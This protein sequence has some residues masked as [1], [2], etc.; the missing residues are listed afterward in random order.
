[1]TYK[2][3]TSMA[4][5]GTSLFLLNN[6]LWILVWLDDNFL[7]LLV[8]YDNYNDVQRIGSYFCKFTGLIA[9]MFIGVYF[10]TLSSVGRICSAKTDIRQ[11]SFIALF[12]V[13]IL[14][15]CAIIDDIYGIFLINVDYTNSAYDKVIAFGK[16]WY[17]IS[18]ILGPIAWACLLLFY[19]DQS[20]SLNLHNKKT[21]LITPS[22]S[23]M[24]LTATIIFSSLIII[25]IIFEIIGENTFSNNIYK[26]WTY[27]GDIIGILSWLL[28]GQFF[29]KIMSLKKSLK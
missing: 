6:I 8:N 21:H 9:W 27:V 15:V 29:A 16:V 18:L 4:I 3:S 12:G 10:Y 1:M 13:A 22:S 17:I 2:V 7:G 11:S 26:Y 23:F 28:I 19:T 5:V 20:L 14:F 25:Q 24:S